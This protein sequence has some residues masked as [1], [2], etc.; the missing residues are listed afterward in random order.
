MTASDTTVCPISHKAKEREERAERGL[1]VCWECYRI[2]HK[3][4][5]ACATC[6]LAQWAR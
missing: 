6:L 5:I 4:G 3:G 1:V 2:Q